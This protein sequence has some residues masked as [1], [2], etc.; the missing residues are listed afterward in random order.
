MKKIISLFA[1][2]S[3]LFTMAVPFSAEASSQYETE[4]ALNSVSSSS[5]MS[6]IRGDTRLTEITI[7]GTHD[8]CA[9]K[10][11]DS[12]VTSTAKCQSLNITEQL[13]AG[14]RFLDVRCECDANSLSVKTVHGSADCWNGNDYYYLDFV[15]QDVYNWL[16]SHPSE[17]V[18]ISIK[19][20][21]G[22]VGA[23]T[24]TRA[25]YEYIHGYGQNKYFYGESYNYHNQWYL[26]KAVPTLDEVRGKCVLM[27][28]FDQVIETSGSGVDASESGQKVKW[29]D[30]DSTS[31]TEPPYVNL[32]NSYSDLTFHVQDYYK[33]NTSNKITATQYM[34]NL[35]HYRGEYYFNF[36]S[37]VSDSLIPNPENLA[38]T[39]NA[40]YPNFTYNKTKP[41]GIFAMDFAT[42][43]L[44]RYII[45]NNEGIS[46]IVTGTDGSISYS[47]NRKT[48]VLRISGN[49]NMN[50]YAYTSAGGVN[51]MGSTAPWGDQLKNSVFDGQYNSDVIN[52]IIVDEGVTSIGAYAFYGYDNVQNIVLPSTI[53]SIGEGAFARCFG[54]QS[55]DIR[56]TAVT[57]IGSYAF[58]DCTSL[59]A[60]YTC[61]SIS[62]INNNIF[63]NAANVVMY[64]NADVYSQ[65]WANANNVTYVVRDLN[66]YSVDVKAGNTAL[67]SENPF[68]GKDLSKGVTISFRKYCN[69]DRGWNSSLLNFSTGL[70]RDN[71]YFIIMANG[72]ILFNDGNGGIAGNNGCYFDI[73]ATAETNSTSPQWVDIDITV[74]KD[75]SG[76][77][78]LKYY[79]DKTLARTYNLN[80]ICAWGYPNGVSGNDGVFSFL[81]SN[82]INLYYGSSF[83]VYPTM[84]GTAESYL[85]KAEFYSYAKSASEITSEADYSYLNAFTDSLGGTAYTGNA[86][87]GNYVSLDTTNNDGRTNTAKLPWA[88][89]GGASSNYISTGVSPFA[90]VNSSNGL[91][92]SFWQRIN[93]NYWGDKESITFAKGDT[94]ECK[95]FTIGT[96]GYIR[97]NNGDGGSDSSLSD[98]RLY[99]DY[100]E[101]AS[102][103]VKQQ[104]K[105]ITLD[106]IDDFHFK[107]F[108]NGQHV[109]DITV[110]G[111][112]NYNSQGGLTDFLTS[113]DT[114]LYFGSYTPY[115]GTCS[116][117][118]DDVYCF[119]RALTNSE[120]YS[121]YLKETQPEQPLLVQSFNILP[122]VHSGQ[123]AL[124]STFSGK[125]GVLYL[126]SGDA[127]PSC[128]VY[129]DN[130]LVNDT[131][132]IE[133]ESDI[134]VIYN[135]NKQVES[136]YIVES[137]GNV[138][139]SNNANCTFDLRSNTRVFCELKN[140][141]AADFSVYS[142]AVEKAS[143]Y[144]AGDYSAD[145]YQNMLDTV[146]SYS[147]IETSG[148]SQVEVD[149][150]VFD[151]LESISALIP[152]LNFAFSGEG[153]SVSAQFGGE[154]HEAGEYSLLFGDE[155]TLNAV[156]ESGY[157]FCGWFETN[158]RRIFS[159]SASFTFKITSNTSYEAVFRA[160]NT[161]TLTFKNYSG[162]IKSTV[163]K[164]VAEWNELDSLDSLLP[165]VPYRLGYIN[166]VWADTASALEQ[167]KAGQDA[168]IRPEYTETGFTPPAIPIPDEDVPVSQCYY[169]Y[170]SDAQTASFVM[171]L[172]V[173]EGCEI[174]SVGIVLYYKKASLFDPTTLDL[175]INNKMLT[176]KFEYDGSD[177]IY[178]LSVS[179]FTSNYNWCV[180]GYAT[181]YDG[182]GVLKVAYSNQINVVDN[183]QIV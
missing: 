74:F 9:R 117:S 26:S 76:N 92:V 47:L 35:G 168:E 57:S 11:K 137:S 143:T 83:S 55:F 93:G 18:L 82:D 154:T 51:G 146:N 176:S 113:S 53:T 151:I 180:R 43:D 135:G 8:S 4:T 122:A 141:A 40:A 61:D 152:Y 161:A 106:I 38:S 33:W 20:D 155:I 112:E 133:A 164:T 50:D 62:S 109:K 175:T 68:A 136:W 107:L 42:S 96:D 81:A 120:V 132:D 30:Y 116:L 105:F 178:A 111:T 131:S 17:T 110:S 179:K 167:L 72:V 163:T 173:P 77:H 79:I 14:V 29:L 36:S 48:G 172:G 85:D 88:N 67:E 1:I 52:T 124:L 10:F 41:S 31:Y 84:S 25:V 22:D 147:N 144:S 2:I 95:Y 73:N 16:A 70:N 169:L 90:N 171:A 125:K 102:Q 60:F 34:L 174:E 157:A 142:A 65:S 78:I 23:A 46:N 49:G 129:A 59:T 177:N 86:D 148:A 128:S 183:Q 150:A 158:T 56:N 6:A 27:N 7:P 69:E 21:D 182:E 32:K 54:L 130:V 101:A 12:Y 64:G 138:T 44:C 127:D 28:R 149:N 162:Q 104:W 156:P 45:N 145:S 15:F 140:D 98:A 134:T 99:F 75:N 165:P 39:V 139:N 5:W 160:E 37:T 159:E 166:G 123:T 94:G 103:I 13:N 118:L 114:K 89:N 100:T 80:E 126:P 24:F 19:E 91:T 115:W 119:N 71:R 63:T 108:I 58:K 66:S 97:F 121:L 87:N 181:Y 3:I 170:N 153:G